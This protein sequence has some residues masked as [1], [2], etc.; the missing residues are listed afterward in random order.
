MTLRDDIIN[1]IVR[2][3]MDQQGIDPGLSP[4]AVPAYLLGTVS[5][6]RRNA[7]PV[8]DQIIDIMLG[9]KAAESGNR[10]IEDHLAAIAPR[11][12]FDMDDITDVDRRQIAR[13]VL[14]A[15]TFGTGWLTRDEAGFKREDPLRIE[16]RD[17]RML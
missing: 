4:D 8:A 11:E 5:Q 6:I 3:E 9:L 13:T 17:R 14:D 12:G 2:Q 7:E 1:T 16:V 15:Y 10:S